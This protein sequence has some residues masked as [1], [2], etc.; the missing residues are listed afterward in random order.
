M[1]IEK[2]LDIFLAKADE[3]RARNT[4]ISDD[5]LKVYLR[6]SA[7]II[8]PTQRSFVFTL[9]IASVVVK[10]EYRRQGIFKDFLIHTHAVNPWQATWVENTW[11]ED[12]SLFLEQDGWQAN[13]IYP[14]CW[15]KL[16]Q[17][18]S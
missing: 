13:E 11:N 3:N 9:D 15:F 4:W 16:K 10:E 12:L 14:M 7:R 2:Q 18:I 17:S 8:L 1:T 6:K 5:K